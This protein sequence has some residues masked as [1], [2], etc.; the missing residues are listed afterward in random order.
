VSVRVERLFVLE[1][2]IGGQRG[3]VHW[4]A[5]A[6]L[7]R[8]HWQACENMSDQG[9]DGNDR[10]GKLSVTNESDGHTMAR[11]RHD[12]HVQYTRSCDDHAMLI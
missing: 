7:P 2:T 11:A 4:A 3:S 1:R 12:S 9:P 5:G 6:V 8:V 10:H